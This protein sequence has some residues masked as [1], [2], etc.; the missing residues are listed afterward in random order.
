MINSGD[1]VAVCLSGGADSMAL[2]H[3]LCTQREKLNINLIAIHIN[4]GL[5]KESE[6]E[7]KFVLEYARENNVKVFVYKAFMSDIKKPKRL[8]TES[9]AREIR[10]EFFNKVH[11]ETG[12]K[13]L[14]AHTAS[15]NLETIIF[16]LTRGTNIKGLKG[17]SKIRE[18]IYR[19]LIEVS[20][21]E[22]EEYCKE[23]AVP[24]VTDK[25]NFEDIYS[26][27][28][29]RLKVIPSLKQINPAIEN[30]IS[31]FS[32][33]M[34]DINTFLTKLGDNLYNNARC[35]N[36]FSILEIL[37]EDP[38]VIKQFLRDLLENQ[39]CLT[40]DNINSIYQNLNKGNYSKQLLDNLFVN[41][42]NK[43]LYFDKKPEITN[44]NFE[45][46]IAFDKE[47]D[48]F[49]KKIVFLLDETKNL[50]KS[51][52]KPF[53]Y[54]I[55]YDKIKSEPKLRNRKINDKITLSK[56]N[57]TKTLKKLFIEDKIEKGKR[58]KILILADGE[59]I[60]FVEN[61]G[62]NKPYEISKNTNRVLIVKII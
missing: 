25:T 6:E 35:E 31:N 20:R 56:R 59:E 26:R 49:D 3:F 1:T 60:V 28:K 53:I 23:N 50:E 13:L 4:H 9:W 36:G 43:V 47:I 30:S 34:E 54:Y 18:N 12:A 8:S 57:V 7:E 44:V 41:I 46:D 2:F 48:F 24:F 42:K 22:I 16:N 55:D 21:A 29:I 62:V 45:I 58:D 51:S 17:I 61:Y 39:G 11:K 32:K 38:V 15:D 40:F 14:T 37:K 5:R 27:N 52:K 33:E 19:P 10:Y